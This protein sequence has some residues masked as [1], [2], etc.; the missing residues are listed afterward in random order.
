MNEPLPRKRAG[1]AIG[2]KPAAFLMLLCL[3]LGVYLGMRLSGFRGVTVRPISGTGA[4]AAGPVAP[5]PNAPVPADAAAGPSFSLDN[6][7]GD[8]PAGAAIAPS[9]LDPTTPEAAAS[10]TGA[11][12]LPDAV[13][14]ADLQTL[15]GRR[16]RLA[17]YAGKTVILELWASWCPSCRAQAP[18]LVRLKNEYA[19]QPDVEIVALSTE[20]P[21][22]SGDKVR[23][24]A[25]E[26]GM[27][28]VTGFIPRD[29]ART[30]AK[31]Q[32]GGGIPIP[33]TLVITPDGKIAKHTVGFDPANDLP[34]IR[35]I[36][37]RTSAPAAAS[38]GTAPS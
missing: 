19:D 33:Q 37:A 24:A 31:T 13:R 8:R 29:L 38:T 1:F 11:P 28:Y 27:N 20:D 35:Q 23:Q 6:G 12:T 7:R 17:D 30:F 15:D 2:W 5:A 14:S 36:I 26:L 22:A 16:F 32:N 10:P 9:V 3:A 21:A 34:A 25:R 18:H 4:P